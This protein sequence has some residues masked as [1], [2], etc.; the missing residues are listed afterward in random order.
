MAKITEEIEREKEMQAWAPCW[1][2]AIT[3][4][5]PIT[6]ISNPQKICRYRY[7]N[8]DNHW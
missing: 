8:T 3:P 4:H 7:S 2:I 6:T 5:P 1:I